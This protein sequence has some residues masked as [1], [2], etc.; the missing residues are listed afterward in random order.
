MEKAEHF[1]LGFAEFA[2]LID[3]LHD[4]IIIYDRHYR[5]VY[6]NRACVRH[7]GYTQAEM[8]GKTFQ[9]FAKE[10]NCWNNSV[11]PTV[12][13]LK[14]PLSTTQQ[15]YLGTEICT[16]ATPLLD[17]QGEVE[18]VLMSVRD[19]SDEGAV[20]RLKDVVDEV[21]NPTE[22]LL[23]GLIYRSPAME[24]VIALARQVCDLTSPCLLL[25]ETGCGKSMLAKY[26]HHNSPRRHKPFVVVN[27]AGIPQELFESELFG[28][29]RGAFTGALTDK[30]GLFAEAEGGTLFLDEISELPLAMQAKLLHAVQE[31]EYRPVGHTTIRQADVKLLAATNRDLF[32]M[33]QS[34]AFRE[35]LYYRLNVFEIQIPPLRHRREDLVPL[36]YFFLN[37][38]NRQYG[39]GRQFSEEALAVMQR[40][41]WRGN[42]RELS[43][44]VERLV[45]TARDENIQV[46][47][48]PAS[49]YETTEYAEPAHAGISDLT[50]A[51]DELEGRMLREA[52]RRH[53][54]SRQVAAALN[55]S[56]TKAVRLMRKHR[57]TESVA[58]RPA[59][60][61]TN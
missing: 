23:E 45:V 60:D 13:R 8:I 54:S 10:D 36:I 39:R 25:G 7:Y 55:I 18:Y 4:E 57:T 43:H 19:V 30:E 34:G 56:Q 21:E 17:E 22:H 16:I 42:V 48:L 59:T 49:L 11:L 24:K 50:R 53:G 29:K 6:V 32:S 46:S 37:H 9:Q 40:Y 1:G 12:Y 20:Q 26:I 35:D 51:L 33:V 15:T 14:K 58:S 38:F 2:R 3:H 61:E 41:D 5:I 31:R 52:V 27:C 44:V 28:H 47:D